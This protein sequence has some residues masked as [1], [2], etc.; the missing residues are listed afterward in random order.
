[1]FT[2]EQINFARQ[3]REL[4][5]RGERV[6]E[7]TMQCLGSLGEDGDDANL[8]STL[9]CYLL[10]A[11]LSVTRTA[12]KMYLH[13]NTIKYRIQRIADRLGFVPGE[14]PETIPLMTACALNRLLRQK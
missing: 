6:V 5:G 11:S 3:C 13:K 9:E 14:F 10:D 1:M 12:E 8:L 4:I 2:L 7:G